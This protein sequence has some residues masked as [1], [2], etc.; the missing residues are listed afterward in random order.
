MTPLDNF[1]SHS[2]DDSAE[3]LWELTYWVTGQALRYFREAIISSCTLRGTMAHLTKWPTGLVTE[4]EVGDAAA[5]S[6]MA[7]W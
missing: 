5:F 6:E 3:S 4:L 2:A 1:A 7:V